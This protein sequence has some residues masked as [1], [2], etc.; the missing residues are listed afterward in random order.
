MRPSPFLRA[1]KGRLVVLLAS[2][3]VVAACGSASLTGIVQVPTQSPAADPSRCMA[4][5][6]QGQLIES[7]QWGIAVREPSG[8]VREV[9][10]PA[11]YS[12]ARATGVVTLRDPSGAAVANTGD[13]VEISGGELGG[14]AWLACPLDPVKPWDR[15]PEGS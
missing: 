8:A 12:A 9:I 1:A 14:G 5:L 10:W 13:W 11:G 2:G 6:L 4:A 15:T 3:V 7:T